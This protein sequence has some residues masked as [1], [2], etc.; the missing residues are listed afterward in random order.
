M[1]QPIKPLSFALTLLFMAVT[2]EFA[3]PQH[4]L[5]GPVIKFE[6]SNRAPKI[7]RIE[8]A[9]ARRGHPPFIPDKEDR[10]FIGDLCEG[11]SEEQKKSLLK[12][13][14][15]DLVGDSDWA[16]IAATLS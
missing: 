4:Q 12:N 1:K 11:C 3:Y 16:D 7:Q 13:V 8:D 10:E 2:G 9:Q 14:R 6:P 15:H 5:L